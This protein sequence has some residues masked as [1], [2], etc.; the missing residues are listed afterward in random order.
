MLPPLLTGRRRWWFG[1]LVATGLVQAAAAAATVLAIHRGLQH[2][3]RASERTTLVVLVGIALV[4][5]W[6][7]TQ[8][9]VLSERLGQDYA[10]QIRLHLVRRV[11]EG[12]RRTS[13]GTTL[14]RASNDLSAIRNWVAQGVSPI[15]VGIPV[16]LGCTLVLVTIDPLVALGVLAPLLALGVALVVG[17]RVAYERSR[18]VRRQ[19]GRLAA[20]LADTLTAA[21]TIRSAG[22]GHRELKR[23]EERSSKVV[24]AA[25]DRARVLGRIRGA[26]TTATGIATAATIGLGMLSALSLPKLA[27]ALAVVGL[28]TSPVQDLGRVVQ[29]RQTFRAAR[30]AI[31]P[32]LASTPSTPGGTTTAVT[33]DHRALSVRG[34]RLGNAT[35]ALPPLEAHDGDRVVVLSSDRA[36]TTA[37][38]TALVGLDPPGAGQITLDGGD[39]LARSSR[40]R[41]ALLGYAA[42][43]MRLERTSIRRAVRYRHPE[44]TDAAVEEMLGRVGLGEKVADLPEGADTTLRE[45]GEPL[46]T[47]DRARLLLARAALGEPRLLVLD[48]LDADLGEAGRAMLRGL[49]AS[50]PGIVVLASDNPAAVLVP[51]RWWD[52]DAGGRRSPLSAGASARP[53]QDSRC[54]PSR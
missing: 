29:Y 54:R 27:A 26:A 17:S 33:S 36:T 14:T 5:G 4:V 9:R 48:H 8:Q 42:Q 52:L 39:I 30:A 20:H 23:V 37:A 38:L 47:P 32:A 51:D 25:V 10:H 2:G 6:T 43:G 18:R 24:Q 44:T 21:S 31:S 49:L 15:A 19:R 1:G 13:L 7:R 40:E 35:G 45:G 12:S 34:V 3:T 53:A 16:V 28:L 50:Y 11:L 22:G 41:R 46:T